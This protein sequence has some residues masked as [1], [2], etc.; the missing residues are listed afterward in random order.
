MVPVNQAASA[1]VQQAMQAAVAH[2][3]AR[4]FQQA[5]ALCR[6]ILQAEPG[7]A[8]ALHLLGMLARDFGKTE[9]ALEL[10]GKAIAARPL[11]PEAHYHLG[12]IRMEQNRLDEAAAHYHQAIALAPGFLEA[13]CNL[14]ALLNRQGQAQQALAS[15]QAAFQIREILEVKIGLAECLQ[16]LSLNDQMPGV[17]PLLTRAMAEAWR[18]PEDL[19]SA[20]IALIKRSPGMPE[21]LAR[22]NRAWP[23]RLSNQALFGGEGASASLEDELLQRL[24]ENA[25]VCDADLERWLTTLRAKLLDAV[26]ME[27]APDETLLAFYCA[28][29]RQCFIN[30]YVFACTAQ[31]ASQVG[32]LQTRLLAAL[33]AGEAVPVLSLLALASYLGLSTLPGAQ[34]L[35]S[36]SWPD[37]VRAVLQQQVVEPQQEEQLRAGIPRLTTFDDAVSRQVQQQY[38]ENPYPRWVRPSLFIQPVSLDE[39]LQKLFPLSTFERLGE[40]D[41]LEVLIAGCGTGQ[42]S[43][44]TARRYRHAQVLAIDLSARSL[45]YAKRKTQEIGLPNLAYAQADIMQL[46]AIGRS[47]DLIE[48]VGVLHHL[49]DPVAGWRVLLSLLRPRGFMLLGFYS[50]QARGPV[51]AARRF[52]AQHGYAATDEDIRRCRQ[53][54]LAPDSAAEL[55]QLA[56]FRDFYG[57]S[58]CRD[59]LFHVQEHRYTLTAL[60]AILDELALD[61]LGFNTEPAILND[62]RARFPADASATDLDNWHLYETANP[63][64]FVG[65]YQFWVQKR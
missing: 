15:Y 22:V 9:L 30:E 10:I 41:P 45:G 37:A 63:Q 46:G 53:D 62:Y 24:L 8:D 34:A 61:F 28:L 6:Q 38:E 32:Q 43:T 44:E 52:I 65:M 51:V 50:E 39:R 19:A 47:F 7:Q 31:E 58:E 25:T 48:S 5:E 57:L 56:T 29:A 40:R 21:V 64:A 20:A 11:F 14:G 33:A 4:R 36:R 16:R 17:R 54:L 26:L 18:R 12:L 13:H 60:K 55:R 35:L 3:Q 1:S 27:R 49:A 59:L 42:H 2:Y 23:D